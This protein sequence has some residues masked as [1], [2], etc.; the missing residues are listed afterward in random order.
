[1][2]KKFFSFFE[3][4]LRHIRASWQMYSLLFFLFSLFT[5]MLRALISCPSGATVF[6]FFYILSL[7]SMF[8]YA[9]ISDVCCPAV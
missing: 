1:M 7:L 8:M 3:S 6:L 2:N 9:N 5:V 4:S